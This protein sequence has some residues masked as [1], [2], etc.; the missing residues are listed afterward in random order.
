MPSKTFLDRYV[1]K[2]IHVWE[3]QTIVADHLCQCHFP[4][5]SHTIAQLNDLASR[6]A[7]FCTLNLLTCQ[8]SWYR[9]NEKLWV[10]QILV[11]LE[12]FIV[13]ASELNLESV[14]HR[15]HKNVPLF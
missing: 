12:C 14:L 3:R 11:C 6:L 9:H 8:Q 13:S 2:M 7:L 5:I 15:G 1:F 4:Y 10:S